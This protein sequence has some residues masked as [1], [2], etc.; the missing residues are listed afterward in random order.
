MNTDNSTDLSE[1]LI[2]IQSQRDEQ[3]CT[4]LWDAVYDRLVALAQQ[5]LTTLNRRMADEEDVAL[6]AVQSFVRAAEAGRLTSIQSR[7]DLWRVLI[8]I[9]VRKVNDLR[10]HL[11]A[12]KRGNALVRGDS[13]FHTMKISGPAGFD[14]IA[15]P[16]DPEDF[17]SCLMEECRERIAGLPDSTLQ[18]IAMKRMEGYEVTE[19]ALQLG[20]SVATIKRKLARIRVIWT[21]APSI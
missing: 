8:T 6:S 18:Q 7:D 10:Q 9:M 21:A 11:D 1:L 12:E 19:I 4:E 16:A 14:Q 3:A 15:A 17:V 13:V 2:R 20:L 5:R